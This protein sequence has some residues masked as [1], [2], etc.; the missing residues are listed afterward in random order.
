MLVCL[1]VSFDIYG[2]LVDKLRFNFLKQ[3]QITKINGSIDL[4]E[5]QYDKILFQQR[6]RSVC[7]DFSISTVSRVS[8]SA[9]SVQYNC[10]RC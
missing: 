1:F 9:Q 5:P 7:S 2:Y 8:R 10:F 6:R 3:S 4:Y